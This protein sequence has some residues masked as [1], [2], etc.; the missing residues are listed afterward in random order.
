LSFD[1]ECGGALLRRFGF[2]FCSLAKFAAKQEKQ[3]RQS[4][5]LPHSTRKPKQKNDIVS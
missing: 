3:K 1:L 4:K 2:S 5:A